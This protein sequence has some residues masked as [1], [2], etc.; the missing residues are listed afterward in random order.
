MCLIVWYYN[1]EKNIRW[2]LTQTL[3]QRVVRKN[4]IGEYSPM[5]MDSLR[6]HP[7]KGAEEPYAIPFSKRSKRNI[8]RGMNI[9]SVRPLPGNP[10]E[11]P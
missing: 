9:D 8:N 6:P 4:I 2:H 7:P 1:T 10:A 5:N 11:G 3:F